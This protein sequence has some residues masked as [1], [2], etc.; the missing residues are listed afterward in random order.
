MQ[1]L[2]MKKMLHTLTLTALL[3]VS[4][5]VAAQI[6]LTGR[7]QVVL[8]G[9]AAVMSIDVAGGAIADFHLAGSSINPLNWNHPERGVTEPKPMGHFICFDRWGQPSKSELENGMTFHGEA[10][11][12]MWDVLSKPSARDGVITA[13]M[14]CELPIGGMT[15]KRTVH[16]H[17]G[18]AVAEVKEEITNINKLG[19]IYNIVQHPSIG[20][21]FLDESTI[22]DCNAL[23]GFMQESPMPTPEE[24]LLYWPT[25]FYHG[26]VVDL[27]YLGGDHRPN[28]TAF[29]FRDGE[30]YGWVT[31]CNPG[32]GLLIGYRWKLSEYP[33]LNIWRNSAE[34]KPT[35]RGLEFGT[36]GLHKP[37]GDLISKGTILGAPLYEYLDAGEVTVKTYSMFLAKIPSDCKG[38]SNVLMRNG[39]LVIS[40]ITGSGRKD[41]ELTVD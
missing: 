29:V 31:A 11:K 39:K 13:E 40:L 25:N 41:I 12:V 23:K 8:E 4:Q 14:H 6:G 20:P 35:A 5:T 37:F 21:P 15:L 19:R 18:S 34:G 36:T 33:W 24:P 10:V 7:P 16:M 28:V 22:V 1:R 38:V 32:Q 26:E 2:L 27:R 30:E 3:A 17:S 9:K